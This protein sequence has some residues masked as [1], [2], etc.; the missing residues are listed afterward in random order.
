MYKNRQF[1]DFIDG[2]QT[3]PTMRE[4]RIACERIE[5]T[6]K[7]KN[8]NY[9]EVKN[10]LVGQSSLSPSTDSKSIKRS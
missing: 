6:I 5:A 7:W 3:G 4:Y 1:T 10:W 2:T 8:R 9:E